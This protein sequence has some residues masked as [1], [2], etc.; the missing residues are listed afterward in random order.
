MESYKKKMFNNMQ[1]KIL[2]MVNKYRR[3]RG[4]NYF[5]IKI[6]DNLLHS[7]RNLAAKSIYVTCYFSLHNNNDIIKT[8]VRYKIYN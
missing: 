4:F 2:V 7:L 8:Y 6:V 1:N 3:R 5:S